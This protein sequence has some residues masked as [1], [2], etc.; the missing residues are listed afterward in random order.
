MH[1]WKDMSVKTEWN[2]KNVYIYSHF[3]RY[4]HMDMNIRMNE[5]SDLDTY[6]LREIE[7]HPQIHAQWCQLQS[8]GNKRL[9]THI[10]LLGYVVCACLFSISIYLM[11]SNGNLASLFIYVLIHV[12]ICLLLIYLPINLVSLLYTYLFI[13][14]LENFQPLL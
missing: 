13:L 2:T 8:F 6:S 3:Y 9:Y 4:T 14:V 10:Q 12:F 7:G 11:Y 5:Q 1:T